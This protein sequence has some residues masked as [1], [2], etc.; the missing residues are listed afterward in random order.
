MEKE[1][2]MKS[3]NMER[4]KF[5]DIQKMFDKMS[6]KCA[7]EPVESVP[8]NDVIKCEIQNVDRDKISIF[9]PVKSIE[10][11][12]KKI[13]KHR[14]IWSDSPAGGSS[15]GS[16]LDLPIGVN[17]NT[18]NYTQNRQLVRQESSSF[19]R[20]PPKSLMDTKI[21][22]QKKDKRGSPSTSSHI[23]P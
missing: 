22:S 9:M 18:E 11:S 8:I 12:A 6:K 7:T 23:I 2:K 3:Q 10:K 19:A 17:V 20:Y 1:A 4:L 14:E 16:I 13:I 15:R 21:S 5:R